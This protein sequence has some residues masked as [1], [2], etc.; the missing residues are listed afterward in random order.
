[1][2]DAVAR[3]LGTA[4]FVLAAKHLGY[5]QDNGTWV[6]AIVAGLTLGM[7]IRNYILIEKTY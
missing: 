5:A 6:P 4:G 7:A 3:V 1:L 2:V